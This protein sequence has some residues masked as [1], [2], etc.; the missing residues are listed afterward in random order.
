MTYQEIFNEVKAM[1][2]AVDISDVNERLV[3]QF[4]ITGEGAGKFYIEV[5]HGTLK[6]EPYD[7]NGFDAEFIA[8]SKVLLKILK[9]QKDPI[10][11]FTFGQIKVNGSIEKALKIKKL[12][13]G[14]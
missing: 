3:Y 5:D 2:E 4:T 12:I 6:I 11:A 1:A 9:G 13:K 8:D 10:V 14:K 7:Y